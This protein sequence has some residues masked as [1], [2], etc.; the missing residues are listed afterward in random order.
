MYRNIKPLCCVTGTNIV[1]QV[2]YTSKTNK[3]IKKTDQIC[4]YGAGGTG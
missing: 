4:G 3:L 2:T 1:L